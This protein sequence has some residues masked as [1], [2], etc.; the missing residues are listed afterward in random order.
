MKG[1]AGRPED[2]E[3]AQALVALLNLT[4]ADE[5]RAVVTTYVPPSLLT[6]RVEYFVRSLL[7]AKW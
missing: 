1:V 2:L 6:S 5:A 7:P 3:D 4:S